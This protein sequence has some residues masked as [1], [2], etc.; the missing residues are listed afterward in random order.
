LIFTIA[1]TIANNTICIY[2]GDIACELSRHASQVYISTR[3]GSWILPR[4]TTGGRPVD[5]FGYCR[6][7]HSIPKK[8]RDWLFLLKL[9]SLFDLANFGLEPEDNPSVR[10]PIINDELPHR[11]IVGSII[12]KMEIEYFKD[13]QVVFKDGTHIDEIDTV[14]FGTGYNVDYPFLPKSI[15]KPNQSHQFY[16]TVFPPEL[17]KPTLAFIGVF[18]I[19]GAVAPVAEMQ[20]RWAVQIL[21]GDCTLPS[22]QGMRT[23]IL[24]MQYHDRM[25]KFGKANSTQFLVRKVVNYHIILMMTH[26]HEMLVV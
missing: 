2:S 17:I 19:N 20:A 23:D 4:L 25:E 6:S 11:I 26:V 1:F 24:A 14:I 9:K 5:V 13:K 16:K 12:T 8:I 10:L 15:F 7:I 3:R 21:N 22:K 18:R